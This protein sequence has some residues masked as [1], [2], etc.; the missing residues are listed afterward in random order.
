MLLEEL[1]VNFEFQDWLVTRAIG[2]SSFAEFV[3]AWHSVTEAELGETDLQFIY[4]SDA[5]QRIALLIEN[6]I[7]APPQ[8]DQAARYQLRGEKGITDGYWE[9]FCTLAIAPA[10]YLSSTQHSSEY[11]VDLSYEEI[12]AFFASRRVQDQR[13]AYKAKVILEAIEQNRRGYQATYDEDMTN[14]VAAYFDVHGK[15]HPELGMQKPKPRPASS[16]WIT[17]IPNGYPKSIWLCHQLFSG[18]VKVFF[19]GQGEQLDEIQLRYANV[20]DPDMKAGIA[21]KSAAI[22]IDVAKIRPRETTFEDVITETNY[23]IEALQRLD[24]MVRSV[25]GIL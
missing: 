17:C 16:D 5:G 21:G 18:K 12:M 20:L 15:A 2:L 4:V 14:F 1:T 19:E 13:F 24:R 22:A 9:D 8:P 25:E 11:D 3:G 10:R 23:A 7:S 6:K